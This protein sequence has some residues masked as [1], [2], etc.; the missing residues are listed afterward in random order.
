MSGRH[1]L[2]KERDLVTL[3]RL[4]K[5][6]DRAPP[7][8]KGEFGRVYRLDSMLDEYH[9]VRGLPQHSIA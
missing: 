5:L 3:A 2:K 6:K 4:G 7:M 8:P 1:V 9:L